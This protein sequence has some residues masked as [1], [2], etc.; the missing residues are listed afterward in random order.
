MKLTYTITLLG[1]ALFFAGCASKESAS[2]DA[3]SG[4]APTTSGSSA[5]SPRTA[6]D[7]GTGPKLLME[8][9]KSGEIE[10]FRD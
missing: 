9:Y 4:M 6:Y 7:G 8:R 2:T 5:T 1:T 10:G 3:S